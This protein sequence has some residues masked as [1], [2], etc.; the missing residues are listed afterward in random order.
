MRRAWSNAARTLH[1]VAP[2]PLP[3]PAVAAEQRPARPWPRRLAKPVFPADTQA[4]MRA[5]SALTGFDFKDG[6]VLGPLLSVEQ[7]RDV[8]AW[9]CPLTP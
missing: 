9:Y 7:A 8:L 6:A 4:R 2:P 3:E 1:P 5:Q